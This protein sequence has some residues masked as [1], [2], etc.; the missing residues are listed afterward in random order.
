MGDGFQMVLEF[1]PLRLDR[2]SDDR[3]VGFFVPKTAIAAVSLARGAF[4]PF[5]LHVAKC[6]SKWC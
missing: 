1:S 4:D 5:G 2:G 6:L 3:I